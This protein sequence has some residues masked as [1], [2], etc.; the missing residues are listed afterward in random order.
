MSRLA[1]T[2]AIAIVFSSSVTAFAEPPL[3]KAEKAAIAKYD[4]L[5]QKWRIKAVAAWKERYKQSKKHSKILKN[6]PTFYP[7]IITNNARGD[8]EIKEGA[9]GILGNDVPG[10]RVEQVISKKK[11]LC[12]L[13]HDYFFVD[14]I[15]TTGVVDAKMHIFKGLFCIAGTEKYATLDGGSNTIYVMKPIS[16][17]KADGEKPK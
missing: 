6:E 15:D 14:D 2:L 16:S 13:G 10:V 11:A 4:D 12:M 5:P 8:T 1:V 17:D 7:S 3:S 9:W